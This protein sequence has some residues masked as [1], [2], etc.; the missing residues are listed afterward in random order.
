M[1]VRVIVRV[2]DR[3]PGRVRMRA[4]VGDREPGRESDNLVIFD[5]AEK[6][7]EIYSILARFEIAT[8][9]LGFR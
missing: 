1:R 8:K 4:R 7:V 2:G 6:N 5:G 3:E 9:L